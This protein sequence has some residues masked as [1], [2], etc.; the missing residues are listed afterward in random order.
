MADRRLWLFLVVQLSACYPT[1]TATA[2]AKVLILGGGMAGLQ[3]SQVFNDNNMKD[4][5][6]LEADSKLGGRMLATDLP[7]LPVTDSW[8]R[9]DRRQNVPD[10]FRALLDRCDLA[11]SFLVW[12]QYMAIDENG[13]VV[14]KEAKR[15][16]ARLSQAINDL[17]EAWGRG[18]FEGKG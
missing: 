3:I 13:N 12:S 15:A 8:F 11:Y 17:K 6:I 9:M 18:D 10:P 7:D 1:E 4:F 2:K 16:Q 5:L 14:T